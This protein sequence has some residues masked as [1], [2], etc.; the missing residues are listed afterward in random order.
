MTDL[1]FPDE[2]WTPL[3]D[4]ETAF[5]CIATINGGKFQ[6]TAYVVHF[7]DEAGDQLPISA[8]YTEEYLASR[9]AHGLRVGETCDPATIRGKECVIQAHSSM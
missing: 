1:T 2:A 3:N 4:D 8:E 9:E 6:F 5:I 7:D